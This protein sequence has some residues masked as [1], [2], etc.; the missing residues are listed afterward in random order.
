MPVFPNADSPPGSPQT[1][2]VDLTTQHLP[3]TEPETMPTLSPYAR[4]HRF[5]TLYRRIHSRR[6][7]VYNQQNPDIMAER[8]HMTEEHPLPQARENALAHISVAYALAGYAQ[9]ALCIVMSCALAWGVIHFAW[10]VWGDVTRKTR[11]REESIIA[12]ALEC[13]ANH[14][15]NGCTVGED[16]LVTHATPALA[17]LCR[18]WDVCEK[19]GRF[20][21]ADAV[22]ASVWSET[23]AEVVNS[24][25]DKISSTSVVIALSVAIVV[26]FLM[27]SAAF[28]FMHRRLV[29]ERL[30]APSSASMSDTGVPAILRQDYVDRMRGTH[31]AAI[32]AG[33]GSGK[34]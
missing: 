16:G 1:I 23:F 33:D 13:A 20:A 22:S 5:N 6:E 4:H 8:L 25:A 27:S 14:V 3:A 18:E 10:G 15:K 32:T 34:S 7:R 19:R 29:D 26:A 30:M 12:K 21:S 17:T 9:A 28:G 11:L 31:T 2:D 24:F